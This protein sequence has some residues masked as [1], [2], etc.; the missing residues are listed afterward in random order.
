MDGGKRILQLRGIQPFLSDKC[1]TSSMTAC[2][3]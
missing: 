1:D 3:S 2:K